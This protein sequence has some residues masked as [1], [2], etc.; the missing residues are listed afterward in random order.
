MKKS[1]SLSTLKPHLDN[2]KKLHGWRS[3]PPAIEN[4]FRD[5]A[6]SFEEFQ[7]GFAKKYHSILSLPT[8]MIL[9]N[10][11]EVGVIYYE[12]WFK[13]D[14]CELSLYLDPKYLD[15]KIG[16]SSLKLAIDEL[17][18]KG[19]K[20]V[21]A[22][23]KK[24]NVRAQGAFT[25]AGFSQVGKVE[26]PRYGKS[27]D[28]IKFEYSTADTHKTF[29][30]AEAGSNCI[31]GSEVLTLE[32]AQTMIK[33]AYIAGADAVKFQLFSNDSI[34][35]PNAG[36]APYLDQDINEIF[37]SYALPPS[38]IPKLSA[39]A[40]YV[41]IE[42]MCSF[43]S[44]NDFEI[45]DPYVQKHKIASYEIRHLRLIEKAARS[46]KPLYLSTGAA[47]LDDIRW[48]Q[49]IFFK[50]GGESLTL[51]HCTA[52][53]PAEAVSLNLNCLTSLREEFRLPVGLSDHSAHPLYAPIAAVTLGATS[54]EK[55]FT[56]ERKLPGPD[57]FFAIDSK[58]LKEMCIAI[59]HTEK[60]LGVAKKEIF[61]Q[62]EELA[63]IAR[64]G[65]QASCMISKGDLLQEGVNV[66]ILR[67]GMQ[68]LG[69]HPKYIEDI[70]GRA[71]AQNIALGCGIQ[72]EDIIW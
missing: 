52:Q 63:S 17:A 48:A 32:L 4:S 36:S 39:Y 43:F 45:V 1:L 57:H 15:L 5:K 42:M 29:I 7:N 31:L 20:K 21:V 60:I 40:Q 3:S 27:F 14:E 54:I 30:I 44:E 19:F 25:K 37:K 26:V 13:D 33:E 65:L 69:I 72:H 71:A 56:L 51:F 9:Y 8:Q 61:N 34:Y 35:V 64:R 6:Q 49:N 2:L 70:E 41:G 10:G 55:H 50:N 28:A 53:Y 47:S 16:T 67:P 11:D 59:I 46:N 68:R 58:E 66:S 24:T 23:V 38:M 12:K 22:F 62:E 18:L